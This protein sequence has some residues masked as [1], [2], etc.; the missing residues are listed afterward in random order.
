MVELEN[1][2]PLLSRAK[3]HM[4]KK[5]LEIMLSSARVSTRLYGVELTGTPWIISNKVEV[6]TQGEN[7]AIR[8]IPDNQ[9]HSLTNSR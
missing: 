5:L 8:I 4:I 3:M 9:Q 7:A 2:H 1:A 6:A